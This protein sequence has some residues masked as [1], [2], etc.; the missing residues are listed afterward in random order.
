MRVSRPNIAPPLVAETPGDRNHRPGATLSAGSQTVL[1]TV[2]FSPATTA[3]FIAAANNIVMAG[4]APTLSPSGSSAVT[5][6]RPRPSALAS[7]GP[8]AFPWVD[9]ASNAGEAPCTAPYAIT[10]SAMNPPT[11]V[12]DQPSTL[13]RKI[14]TLTTNHTSRAAKRASRARDSRLMSVEFDRIPVKAA[15][16]FACPMAAG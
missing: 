6:A 14:G 2:G 15:F 7:T 13:A 1:P 11:W 16:F 12:K 3:E 8:G 9:F 4:G 10:H 5:A